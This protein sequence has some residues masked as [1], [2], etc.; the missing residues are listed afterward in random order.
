MRTTV[1]TGL[2]GCLL[3]LSMVA[4]AQ[5]APAPAPD[6]GTDAP[7][8]TPPP[9]PSLVRR[10]AVGPRLIIAPGVFIPSTGSAGFTL[11]LAG[12]YGF[13]LGPVILSPGL[14]AQGSW[15]SDWNVYTGLGGLRVTLPLGNFG[16]YLEGG[17]GYGHVGG[18]HDYSAGGLALRC[19]AGFILFFSQSFALG[20]SVIYDT[21]LDTPYKSWGI[22]P[23]IL[24]A[25]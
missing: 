8:L 22:A 18:P 10:Y 14:M 7:Q 24:L 19:G 12:G 20:L 21:I 15:S 6:V 9:E 2:S 1:R 17:I 23:L 16:P 3:L 13:D 11:G 25:F 5:P 4:A